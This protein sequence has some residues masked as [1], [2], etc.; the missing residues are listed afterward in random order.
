MWPV[1]QW[2]WITVLD[3]VTVWSFKILPNKIQITINTLYTH[4][5]M[6]NGKFHMHTTSLATLPKPALPFMCFV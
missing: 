1:K 5:L 4:S 2:F 3:T 6:H